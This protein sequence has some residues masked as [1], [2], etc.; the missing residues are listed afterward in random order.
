VDK[1]DRF[2]ALTATTARFH[3]LLF[4]V[5]AHILALPAGL[6]ADDLRGDGAQPFLSL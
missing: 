2:D 3:Q 5:R 1:G 6:A 4:L